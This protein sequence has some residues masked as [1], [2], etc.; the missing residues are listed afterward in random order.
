MFNRHRIIVALG[1]SL[2]V[3]PGLAVRGVPW[4]VIVCSASGVFCATLADPA[5][6]GSGPR[7]EE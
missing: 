6:V 5:R 3:V 4:W 7:G 1:A 2:A